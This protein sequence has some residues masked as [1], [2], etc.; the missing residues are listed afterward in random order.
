MTELLKLAERC[1]A[2][3]GPDR[4]LD[5]E[6][7][8]AVRA[9]PMNDPDAWIS[10]WPHPFI[11]APQFKG[12]IAAPNNAGGI[13]CH[14]EARDYTA[15]ID[16]A[17][18]LIAA[19]VFFHVS[20]FSPE[21]D[22]RGQAHVYPNRGI[23]D[24]YEAEAATPALALCAAALRARDASGTEAQRAATENT[25]AVHDGPAPKADA[26]PLPPELKRTGSGSWQ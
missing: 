19:D 22:G 18:T 17:M 3:S 16:A 8:A 14:W 23:G 10:G 21:C 13:V 7:G 25:D 6:I 26:Q 15:S 20:R 5:A 12:S 24:D 11:A 1:E 4:R 9:M 2:A